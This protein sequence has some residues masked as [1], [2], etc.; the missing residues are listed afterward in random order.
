MQPP[1]RFEQADFAVFLSNPKGGMAET[2]T[3]AGRWFTG[4]AT[5]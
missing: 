1:C 3:M 2:A 5:R 4:L